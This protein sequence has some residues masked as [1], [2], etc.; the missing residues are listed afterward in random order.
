MGPTLL[1]FFFGAV[2]GEFTDLP[3]RSR[4]CKLVGCHRSDG[5]AGRARAS[6]SL[7]L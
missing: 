6:C 1:I 7:E 5:A 4:P 2:L 3:L